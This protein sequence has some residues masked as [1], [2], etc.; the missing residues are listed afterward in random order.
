[1]NKVHFL[2]VIFLIVAV[3]AFIPLTTEVFGD[4][5]PDV[6]TISAIVCGVGM[7]GS[8]ICTIVRVIRELKKK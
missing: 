6:L 3:I 2:S 8:G 5:N 1:M 4:M 7:V